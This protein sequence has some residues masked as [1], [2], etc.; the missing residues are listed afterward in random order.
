ML[1]SVQSVE[2][3]FV[4]SKV[5]NVLALCLLMDRYALKRVSC[6]QLLL[7]LHVLLHTTVRKGSEFM[8]SDAACRDPMSI[9]PSCS[10]TLCV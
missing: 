7:Y 8:G 9:D 6:K 10:Y 5:G 4:I 1:E 3:R 2:V